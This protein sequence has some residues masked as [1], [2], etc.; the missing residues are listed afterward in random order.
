MS[1]RISVPQTL[2]VR[3]VPYVSTAVIPAA[4]SQNYA[5]G[6]LLNIF[7]NMQTSWMY[8]SVIQIALNGSQPSWASDDWS[9]VP[10]DLS[11][12][13]I[14]DM[15]NVGANSS[16]GEEFNISRLQA[17]LNTTAL[18]ARLECSPSDM[19]DSSRWLTELDLTNASYWNVSVNPS[20]T[21]KGYE[22]GRFVQ[23]E[24]TSMEHSSILITY[25]DPETVECGIQE[26][27]SFYSDPNRLVC[28]ENITDDVV[29]PG[30][31][32]YWSD[33]TQEFLAELVEPCDYG[34]CRHGPWWPR[35]I[36]VK[37]VHGRPIEG[38]SVINE[39]D[40]THMVWAEQPA[41]SVSKCIPVIETA[42]SW[43]E[44][45]VA[46]GNVLDFSIT[47][48]PQADDWAWKDGYESHSYTEET[49]EDSVF[50]ITTSYGILF[51][52]ALL[53]SARLDTA[54]TANA[55]NMFNGIENFDD[56][57]FKFRL[58][59]LNVDYMTYAMLKLVDDDHEA[60]LDSDTL[61]R[62]ASKVFSTFF[63]HFVASNLSISD[64]GWAYQRLDER[65]P[66][67]MNY[68]GD[69]ALVEPPR[70]LGLG[71]PRS[72]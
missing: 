44:V 71:W 40:H 5:R 10:V 27:T 50:N 59:G 6:A 15:Q 66:A 22:L 16:V 51:E 41:L 13:S 19:S 36:A 11:K 67:D 54:F 63:Q 46:T 28:C 9:F 12:V 55:D 30:S 57:T 47:G 20:Y 25:R 45:D 49:P 33:I 32:G 39:T 31:T 17:R 35:S 18:R 72:R 4:R 2:E 26:D 34:D 58:L 8:S 37:W 62:S 65:L 70:I 61:Q 53:K 29:G 24:D 14:K 7:G 43:V 3:Q 21:E 23:R 68:E 60:L 64:S 56:R 1:Q 52:D 38:Y 42:D 69:P 48:E